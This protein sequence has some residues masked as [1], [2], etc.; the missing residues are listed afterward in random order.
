VN[1]YSDQLLGWLKELGY[2]HC[3]FLAGGNIMHVLESASKLFTC[4]PVVHE[5]TAG[6]AAEYFN[7]TTNSNGKKA[8]ALV[9]AGPGLTNIVT[10][11]SGAYL[12]GRD[13]LVIGGQVK[14]QD[15]KSRGLRQNGIQ[16]IDG[17]S[18]VKSICKTTLQIATPLPAKIVKETI[19]EGLRPKK[20]PVFLE[21]CLDAQ[22][23]QPLLEPIENTIVVTRSVPKKAV[24]DVMDKVRESKRP[25]ILI[26][27]G[28]SRHF[29]SRN[30]AAL[31]GLQIPLMT[32]W[33]GTDRI[34]SNSELY[35]GRPNTWGQRSSNILI[36]Q[37]DLVIAV[38]TRLG[39]QQT[40]FNW[41]SFAPLG[42]VIQVELDE[43]EL[44]KKSPK[45]AKKVQ[46]DA[47][48]FLSELI[49]FGPKDDTN[50]W[51]KFCLMVRKII[52]LSE[53]IN[54]V[55]DGYINT[56]NFYLGLS[57]HLNNTD[58]IVPSSSGAS[59]TVAM[60]A[61]NQISG[62]TVVTTKG[63]A[64]MGYGLAGA[65][66]C[67]FATGARVIHIEGDGGF[68]QNLQDFGT[69]VA[70]EL[71]IK[72]FILC[73][74]GYASIRMTQKS[75]FNGHYLGCDVETGLML[76]DW[77]T[78]FMAYGVTPITLD[79]ADPFSPKVLNELRSSGPS[80]FLVPVDPEQTYFPKIT[81]KVVEGGGMQ[82]NPLHFMTPDLPEDIAKNVFK[83][84]GTRGLN[85]Q[86]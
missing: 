75:Y 32:T 41:E 82:S 10:A 80:V 70:N 66:G 36:Q 2:T 77:S 65:I 44:N 83:Y 30:L 54:T 25:V 1:N 21:F 17:I 22:A 72:T 9:T 7:E 48:D 42:D 57:M 5:V 47:D 56:Y 64:S 4:I 63:L 39:L 29:M 73:N 18:L 60:Q 76:P 68:A 38:G 81:S 52:P 24:A 26:G 20:G 49:K 51:I 79:P 14:S 31:E 67:A 15:L 61:L 85:E 59:E 11:I 13:L 53:E 78:F 23:A 69:V 86:D 50:E 55:R 58:S 33:N 19:L 46:M 35:F 40:G 27:G 43:F 45:L 8:F 16:E 37:A 71:P 74:D 12:E 84:I 28:V 34:P 62:N 3:F 6:I